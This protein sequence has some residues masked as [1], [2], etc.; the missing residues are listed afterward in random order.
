LCRFFC[1]RQ[2]T[3]SLPIIYFIRGFY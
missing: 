2:F 3:L 1:F